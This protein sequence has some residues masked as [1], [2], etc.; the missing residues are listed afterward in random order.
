MVAVGFCTIAMVQVIRAE[1]DRTI[2]NGM[3]A[4][5]N[6]TDQSGKKCKKV[7]T[8]EGVGKCTLG[9]G[10]GVCSQS[11]GGTV[12]NPADCPQCA[13][14]TCPAGK[15]L[16]EKSHGKCDADGA[17][18]GY[19]PDICK[20]CDYLVCCKGNGYASILDCVNNM[21]PCENFFGWQSDACKP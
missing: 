21:N 6:P 12:T 4:C 20:H 19:A 9:H 15:I 2:L 3:D 8:L 13:N 11:L 5:Q 14:G 17:S 10:P 7:E 16:E 1:A 18:T